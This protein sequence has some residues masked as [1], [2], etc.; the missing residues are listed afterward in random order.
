MHHFALNRAG[1]HDGH[2]DDQII[3]IAR[4]QARQ[5]G[6]LS[7]RLDLKDPDGVRAA[8][9]VVHPRILARHRCQI[10]LPRHSARTAEFVDQI[11]SPT[12]CGEHA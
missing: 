12:Y 7:P 6:H 5:H 2:L 1:T 10:E 11:K 4:S 3:V 8:D 9:H